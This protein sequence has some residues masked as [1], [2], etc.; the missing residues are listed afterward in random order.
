MVLGAHGG[1]LG[2]MVPLYRMGLGGKLSTGEQW[3]S[4]IAL[5]DLVSAIDHI[6]KS[7]SVHGPV[8]IVSTQAV[9]QKE[10]SRRLAE[11]LHRPAFITVPAWLLRLQFG[12]VA[13]EVL[14]ASARVVPKKLCASGFRF[15]YSDLSDALHSI[16]NKY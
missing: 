8:N 16:L 5:A 14:L 9:R 12:V 6:L 7:D 1:A 13:D 10:F 3:M 11:A 4:W 2:K 15:K